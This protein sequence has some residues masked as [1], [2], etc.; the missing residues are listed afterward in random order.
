M[1]VGNSKNFGGNEDERKAAEYLYRD[2]VAIE[3]SFKEKL[4]LVTE[5][6]IIDKYVICK[7]IAISVSFICNKVQVV[8]VFYYPPTIDVEI[9]N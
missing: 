2:L 7:A 6:P 3:K 9:Y 4:S 1:F 8:Y 5:V